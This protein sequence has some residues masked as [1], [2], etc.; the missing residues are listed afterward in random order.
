MSTPMRCLKA[1]LTD[2]YPCPCPE[3]WPLPPVRMV[4]DLTARHIGKR[5]RIPGLHQPGADWDAPKVAVEGKLDKLVSVTFGRG[6]VW[7][8]LTPKAVALDRPL[9][10]DWAC[11]VLP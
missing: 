7:V 1:E 8:A 2:G 3:C 6:E 11:E 5:I 10:L 9:P 4:G